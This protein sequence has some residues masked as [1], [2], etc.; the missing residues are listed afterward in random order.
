MYAP[1]EIEG[2]AYYLKPMNCPHHHMIYKARPRSYRELPLRLA[3]F[4]TVYRFELSG[5][6][7]G[8]T[9]ARALPRTMPTSTAH[10]LRL[11]RSSSGLFSFLMR[12]TETSVSQITG[13][14]SRC[15]TSST[16]PKNLARKTTT[17]ATPSQLSGP[18]W[19]RPGLSTWRALA[20]PPFMSQAGRA[21][22]QRAG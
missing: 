14:A 13:S 8:L 21:D 16:I 4:G 2:E 19:N 22:P 7:S 1:I 15:Q 10:G 11:P 12:C 5:T 3:E 18:R 20:R 17:G 6:L 9:R